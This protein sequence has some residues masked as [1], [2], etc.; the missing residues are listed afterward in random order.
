LIFHD[1]GAKRA[2]GGSFDARRRLRRRRFA[3]GESPNARNVKVFHYLI[4]HGIDKNSKLQ[5]LPPPKQKAHPLVRNAGIFQNACTTKIRAISTA[6]III[7]HDSIAVY[8]KAR[9]KTKIRALA[10]C[11]D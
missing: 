8:S 1:T 7:V 6:K 11:A 10:K 9:A 3:Y 4:S 5:T 2:F